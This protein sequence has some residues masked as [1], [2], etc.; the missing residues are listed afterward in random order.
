MAGALS[1]GDTGRVVAKNLVGT[2]SVGFLVVYFL[3]E[4]DPSYT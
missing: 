3:H 4:K 2:E 1:V